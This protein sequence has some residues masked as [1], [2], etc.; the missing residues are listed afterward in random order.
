MRMEVNDREDGRPTVL[1]RRLGYC[2]QFYSVA[3][4]YFHASA[5][6]RYLAELAVDRGSKVDLLVHTVALDDVL[7]GTQRR[8]I[9]KRTT[10]GTALS[11]NRPNDLDETARLARDAAIWRGFPPLNAQGSRIGAAHGG[12][13]GIRGVSAGAAELSGEQIREKHGLW[14]PWGRNTQGMKLPSGTRPEDV[15]LA[16]PK[17]GLVYTLEDL[18]AGRPLP[19]PY[20][21][22]DD[23][24]GLYFPSPDDPAKGRAWTPIGHRVSQLYREYYHAVGQSLAQARRSRRYDDAHDA[25]IGLV[26]WA[27]GFPAL[28]YAEFLSNTVHERG[29]FGRDYSCRR[30]ETTAEFLPHYQ[31]YVRPIMFQY[32]ELFSFLRNSDL[33]ARSVRRFVPWVRTGE[34]VIRLIDVY[35]VQTTAKRILRYHY[36]TDPMDIANLAA[37]VGDRSVTDP[38]MEWLFTR[39]F[40]YPLP[41]AGIQDTMI[42]G[43]TREGTE[44]VGSTYYAQGEGALRVAEALDRYRAAGGNRLYDLSDPARYPKPSAH[45]YWRIE[46]VVGGWDFLRIGDVCG[47]DKT[48]G[49]TLRDLGFARSGWRWTRDPRFAFILKHYLGRE[50]TGEKEWAE[51]AKAAARCPRAPWLDNRSRVLPMWAGVLEAGLEHDDP[52]FRRAAYLRVGHGMGHQH[53]DTFDL[54]I[55]AH[56]LPM[57]VDGGQRPGYS[58]PGDRASR[59]HNTVEVDDRSFRDHSWV[60]AL[61]DRDGA[62]YLAARACPPAGARLYRRQVALIDIDPPGRARR[63]SVDQQSPNRS[64]VLPKV[65]ATPRS[66]VFD[67]FRVAGGDRHTYCFHGSL[68]D[69]FQWNAADPARPAEGSD[70]AQYLALFKVKPEMSFIGRAGEHFQ[71]TWRMALEMP[72]P[73]A[74]EKEM[75]GRSYDPAAPRKYTRL[76]LL[77]AAGA[78]A[79]RGQ[80]VCRQWKYEYTNVMVRRRSPTGQPLDSVYAAIIE[81]YAGKPFLTGLRQLKVEGAGGGARRPVAVEVKTSSGHTDVCFADAGDVRLQEVPDAKLGAAAEF[82]YH[83]T[84]AN[85]LRQVTLVAGTKLESP[86]VRIEVAEAARRAKVVK[87]DYLRRQVWIDRPW[88]RCTQPFVIEVGPAAT[89]H[90]TTCTVVRVE[91][92]DGGSI[93]TLQ[94]GADYYRSEI[95]RFAPGVVE[96]TLKPLL[97]YVR[98]NHRDWVASNDARTKF[99]RAEYLGDGRFRLTTAS[100][101]SPSPAPIERELFGPRPVLDLWEYGVGDTAAFRTSVS[102]RRTASGQF[103][104]EADAAVSVSLRA[105]SAQ[106]SND[107]KAWADLKGRAHEGW[108]TF[109]VSAGQALGRPLRIRLDGSPGKG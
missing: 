8:A 40:I 26:R 85:G 75:L 5:K 92:A 89:Q 59:I 77:G 55:V 66:Y 1:R 61:A 62:R 94:R 48:P 87:V 3:E 79:M 82:A 69:D 10:L 25:A 109:T 21:L 103:L 39:T 73:G 15:F 70:E 86:H 43:T 28:D 91:P 32:D 13:G 97:G 96:C 4:L 104:L 78:R 42:S 17:L 80:A 108:F 88:P 56:G 49:H 95:R 58:S 46:N 9:K 83:S 23:G 2:D 35:L 24:A 60:T 100:G 76:H 22:K 37:V 33:L 106:V 41:V 7:A 74:G 16:N 90:Q 98:G 34:D 102:L 27:Y 107:G 14:V 72:G 63:L 12:Y 11:V 84:D 45:A 71:A 19:A 52:R 30:R 38:W 47:P 101:R 93:L 20:P 67:V 65:A 53:D 31:L 105:G 6:R 36:H 44:Y 54:Q 57:T 50:N 29:P 51:I 81:P 99:W 64:A 68:H 18:H